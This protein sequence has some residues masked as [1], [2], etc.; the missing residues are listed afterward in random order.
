[1]QEGEPVQVLIRPQRRLVHQATHGKVRQQ[2]AP[3]L[4]PHQVGRLAAQN[5][6]RPAQMRLQLGQRPSDLP[7][8]VR[9]GGQVGGRRLGGIQDRRHRPVERL[10]VGDA[11]QPVR[12]CG[13]SEPSGVS[14]T[15]GR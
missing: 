2:Q 8:L 9:E 13:G 10:G 3:E 11:R 1:M 15:S 7:L 4:L 14:P 6:P 5:H 12:G